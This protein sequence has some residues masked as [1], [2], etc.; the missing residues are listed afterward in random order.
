MT[1]M[2]YSPELAERCLK[3]WKA[4]TEI[5][6]EFGGDLE[7][8]VAYTAALEAGLIKSRTLTN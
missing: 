7:A 3:E 8:Y 4:S 6:D 1:S 5:Q 2:N